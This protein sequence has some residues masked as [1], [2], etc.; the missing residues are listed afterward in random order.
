M[1]MLKWCGTESALSMHQSFNRKKAVLTEKLAA[2]PDQRQ[3][4]K[5][6]V[7]A[8]ALRSEITFPWDD[9]PNYSPEKDP[10]DPAFRKGW[11]VMEVTPSRM[12]K[13]HVQG[14]LVPTFNFWQ[15]IFPESETSYESINDALK[16][17]EQDDDIIGA[18]M[19]FDSGGG[20]AC[21]MDECSANIRATSKV[22]P[23]SGY[24]GSY[25]FSASY[26]LMSA[27]SPIYAYQ[28][29]EV[30][31]IGTYVVHLSYVDAYA[32]AGISPTV[33]RAGQ[34]KALGL[35]EEELTDEAKTTMQQKVNESNGFFLRTVSAHRGVSLSNQSTWAEG[36]TFY[37]QEAQNVGL[38]DKVGSFKEL[39]ERG[40][41]SYYVAQNTGETKVMNIDA[42]KMAR[43]GEGE[44]PESVLTPA[45]L[46]SYKAS[47]EGDTNKPEEPVEPQGDEVKPT[48]PT[49]EDEK[50]DIV[51][52]P[53]LAPQSQDVLLD[54]L[55]AATTEAATLRAESKSLK[56]QAVKA[57]ATAAE[58]KAMVETVMPL[59]KQAV[60]SLQRILN[61]PVD[62]NMSAQ[63]LV[64][65]YAE[66]R[67]EQLQ[68]FPTSQRSL[69]AEDKTAPI[70]DD[71][72][73]VLQSRLN[74]IENTED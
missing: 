57:E 44:A 17:V 56:E 24:T 65:A 39:F 61:K 36:K 1:N 16:I 20:Y 13:I 58:A 70:M 68:R 50:G 51:K 33:I 62:T 25:S 52:E 43:I 4:Y 30:G 14:C 10:L 3:F 41:V 11:S 71:A 8:G 18:V 67:T 64:D 15:A 59:A 60:M 5:N 21:G 72:T 22:K 35:P 6:L 19:V 74:A 26:C 12:A 47:I 27:T 7:S 38:V 46:K 73:L 32:E 42:A 40:L 2:A 45:E 9:N 53:E 37:A 28:A 29:A 66:L 69:A 49:D 63:G 55:M 34:F 23:I 48:E 54:R 31:S